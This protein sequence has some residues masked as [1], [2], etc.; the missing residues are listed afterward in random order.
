MLLNRP[1]IRASD[2][3]KMSAN[4][5]LISIEVLNVVLSVFLSLLIF[6]LPNPMLLCARILLDAKFPH[7]IFPGLLARKD[8]AHEVHTFG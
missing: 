4:I 7:V 2:L 8:C 1:R 5:T 6:F 3:I